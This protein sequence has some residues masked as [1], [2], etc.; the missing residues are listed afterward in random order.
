MLSSFQNPR[1]VRVHEYGLVPA[2]V[3]VD[4]VPCICGSEIG[5]SIN[6]RNV[7]IANR[8]RVSCAHKVTTV[9][10]QRDVCLCTPRVSPRR[11]HKCHSGIFR[12]GSLS[13]GGNTYAAS[14][15]FIGYSFSLG[16]S[17]LRRRNKHGTPAAA[18]WL[19]CVRYALAAS[20]SRSFTGGGS[21]S[22]TPLVAAAAATQFL[23][24]S[25]YVSK[26]GAY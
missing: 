14:T 16:D 4:A 13:Q 11:S 1:T 6:T 10:L 8:S 7:A 22:V 15:N 24:A 12:W 23:S 2:N 25:L 9:S 17:F 3:G 21:L 20:A 19:R 5:L 18:P 26:R